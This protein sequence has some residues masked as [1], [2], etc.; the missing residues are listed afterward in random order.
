[1]AAS[2]IDQK[3]LGRLCK[4]TAP[5]NALLSSALYQ[6]LGISILLSRKLF[7][8]RKVRRLDTTR[9]T[10]SLNL[11]HHIIWLS[12]E[13]LSITEVYILPYCQDAILGPNCRVMAAKLRASFY[14]VF[15]LFHNHPPILQLSPSSKS[16]S[17]G[18]LT[19]RANNGQTS[20]RQSPP[21]TGRE[22]KAALRDAIPS[23]T[24]ETSYVTNPFAFDGP[25]QSPP[26]SYPVP[27]IPNTMSPSRRT[28]TR[29]PGLNTTSI[30][31]SPTSSANFLLPPLNFVPAATGYFSAASSLARALLPGSDPLRLST[32]LEHSA[33]LWDCVRDFDAARSFAKSAIRDVYAAPEGMDDTEFADAATLVQALGVMARRGETASSSPPTVIR[34]D[35][36]RPGI[37][38]LTGSAVLRT[39]GATPPTRSTTVRSRQDQQ[40]IPR[41][42]GQQSG[43][44]RT[45]EDGGLSGTEG[46]STTLVGSPMT[47][48]NVPWES[49]DRQSSADSAKRSRAGSKGKQRRRS[50]TRGL[51]DKERKRRLVERAEEAVSR[52]NSA[53]TAEGSRQATPPHM[54]G[55]DGKRPVHVATKENVDTTRVR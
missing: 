35:T 10:K 1:M 20:Q 2:E 32:A 26:P 37:R 23:I 46:R 25:A 31:T 34:S 36:R 45:P 24:S 52:R 4:E 51:S 16:T 13:G 18:P 3:L 44:A 47:A 30:Q 7:R 28:P 43:T 49:Q 19:P 40:T 8:A 12:R 53:S 21:R 9:E 38:G 55:D 6:V 27:P 33:F 11:Y 14:H 50:P 39:H 5:S 42:T 22:R 54:V 29:P 17:T 15:C 41:G 48:T